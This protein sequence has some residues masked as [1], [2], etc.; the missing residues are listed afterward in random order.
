VP[1]FVLNGPPVKSISWLEIEAAEIETS[2]TIVPAPSG[3]PVA[4]DNKHDARSPG[5]APA[6]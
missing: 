2:S 4:Q 5:A 6:F 3:S 1:S